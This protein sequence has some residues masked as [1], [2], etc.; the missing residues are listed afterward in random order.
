[1]SA[2][3]TSAFLGEDLYDLNT[4]LYFS[5]VYHNIEITM[6]MRVLGLGSPDK[7]PPLTEKAAIELGGDILSEFFVFGTGVVLILIEYMRQSSNKTNK[8]NA[9]YQKVIEL[10]KECQNLRNNSGSTY[11]RL[12]EMSSLV[13][14]LKSKYEDINS[15]LSKLVV[16]KRYINQSIQTNNQQKQIGKILFAKKYSKEISFDVKNS[17]IYQSTQSALNEILL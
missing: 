7:V 3:P 15:K 14:E 13:C 17:I 10:E 16:K 2:T 12:S 11:V 9:L 6:R 5:K 1:M 4:Y 8:D